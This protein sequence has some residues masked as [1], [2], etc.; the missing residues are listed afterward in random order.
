MPLY[1]N[2]RWYSNIDNRVDVK[3]EAGMFA[4]SINGTITNSSSESKFGDDFGY[5]SSSA[6]YFSVEFLVDY[7]YVPNLQISYLSMTENQDNN[8][9]QQ[10][11]VADGDFN[12]TV[13]T[14]IEYSVVN[15][16]L[17]QEFKKKGRRVSAFGK[18]IYSGDFEVDIGL[19]AKLVSW[20]FKVRNS[21]DLTLSPS[22]IKADQLIPLPYL[23]FKYY[24][25]DLLVYA[26]TSNLSLNDAKSIS[27][28]AGIDYRVVNK[29]Y[30]SLGYIY[31]QFEIVHEEDTVDFSEKGYK[32]SFKYAF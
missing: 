7:D 28:Q 8:L 3:V 1:A 11:K 18:S 16:V 10:V 23:G 22:W 27:Y 30:L 19:N 13:S 5:S 21:S 24:F 32:L 4:P 14:A 15:I 26:N 12:S 9:S 29:V 25:Y 6:S 31:E 20:S 2:D 17:Y